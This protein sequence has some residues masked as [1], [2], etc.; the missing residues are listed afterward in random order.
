MSCPVDEM[1]WVPSCFSIAPKQRQRAESWLSVPQPDSDIGRRSCIWL[2]RGLMAVG[3]LK[4]T[5][6][7]GVLL[8]FLIEE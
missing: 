4:L 6:W 7:A 8:E 5:K 1:V 3:A 2:V